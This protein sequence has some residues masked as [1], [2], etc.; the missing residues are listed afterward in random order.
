MY[1][2]SVVPSVINFID[3]D[4]FHQ[5]LVCFVRYLEKKVQNSFHKNKKNVILGLE[6]VA[7]NFGY[8]CIGEI[9]SSKYLRNWEISEKG[10]TTLTQ[11]TLC[12]M[13]LNIMTQ[14]NSI[15][16][17]KFD[18]RVKKYTA[19]LVT[20][21]AILLSVSR[22]SVTRLNVV[23]PREDCNFNFGNLREPVWVVQLKTVLVFLS[24]SLSLTHTHT[25]TQSFSL[26]RTNTLICTYSLTLARTRTHILSLSH[27]HTHTHRNTLSLSLTHTHTHTTMHTLFLSSLSLSLSLTHTHTQ[28]HTFY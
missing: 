15:K 13:T 2:F 16:F 5:F 27:T 8:S 26:S 10:A 18:R 7:S 12:R 23:A 4:F 1:T 11:K 20:I 19:L 6:L 3:Q 24:L 21:K 9:V 28:T 22:L 17:V 14:Y 25:R